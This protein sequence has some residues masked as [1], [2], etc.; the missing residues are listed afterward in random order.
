MW[1]STINLNIIFRIRSSYISV[2]YLFETCILS[3]SKKKQNL[4]NSEGLL[5]HRIHSIFC[6]L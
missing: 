6:G 4:V 2:I 1:I 5:C 3:S